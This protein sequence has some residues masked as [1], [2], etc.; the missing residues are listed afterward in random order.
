MVNGKS[1]TL[2]QF[3]NLILII[4]MNYLNVLIIL[5]CN[6]YGNTKIEKNLIIIKSERSS[7][8]KASLAPPWLGN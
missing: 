4:E 5:I 3:Q 2:N 8:C 6:H 1:I 7:P